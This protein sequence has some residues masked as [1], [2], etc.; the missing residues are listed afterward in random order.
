MIAIN[1]NTDDVYHQLFSNNPAKVIRD[2][3]YK[4][5]SLYRKSYKLAQGADFIKQ[6][7]T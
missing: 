6:F 7:L 3:Y 5:F 2:C 4:T 1:N